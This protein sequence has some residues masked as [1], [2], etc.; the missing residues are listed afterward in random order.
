[1]ID[2]KQMLE[3]GV[4]FGHKTSRWSPKMRPYIW[5]A[6]N[7]VH[8]IDVSKTAILLERAGNFLKDVSR[9]GGKLLFVGTKK[10]AQ[11]IIQKAAT[12]TRMPFVIHRWVGGTLSNYEQVKKAVTRLLHMRDVLQKSATHYKKKEISMIQKEIAR[13]EKN[14]GGIIDFDYPPAAIIVIDVKKE[15]SALKE[16]LSLGIPVVA[17]VDTNSDP[18]GITHVIPSNDDSPKAI[19]FVISYL[20]GRILEGLK[21]HETAQAKVRAEQ[22]AKRLADQEARKAAAKAAADAHAAHSAKQQIQPRPVHTAVKESTVKAP[23]KAAPVKAAPTIVATD[24]KAPITE[25]KLKKEIK[26]EPPKHEAKALKPV[27]AEPKVEAKSDAKK[28][29]KKTAKSN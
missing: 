4:H 13:L 19:N 18:S 21:E 10:P 27:K 12:A 22:D 14:V 24:A 20:E 8:L 15:H 6:K 17:L 29:I 11:E 1:M 5:G 16:A 2:L 7:R 26:V 9:T 3:A 28:E 25:V 23:E